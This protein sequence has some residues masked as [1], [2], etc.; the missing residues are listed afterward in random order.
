M[1]KGRTNQMKSPKAQPMGG[2]K[3]GPKGRPK[4]GPNTMGPM[5]ILTNIVHVKYTKTL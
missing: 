4:R 2:P 5:K 1:T 3:S